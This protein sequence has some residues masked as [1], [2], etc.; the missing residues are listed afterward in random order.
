[1]LRSGTDN[2]FNWKYKNDAD[3][4][5]CPYSSSTKGGRKW[6]A[7]NVEGLKRYREILDF[8][9]AG[10]AKKDCLDLEKACL[11]RLRV[12]YGIEQGE[13]VPADVAKGK[14]ATPYDD[15]DDEFGDMLG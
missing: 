14:K 10:R 13:G 7:F 6:G 9:K 1:M 8:A 2:Q 3:Y 12:S 11:T 5:N 4:M 15:S